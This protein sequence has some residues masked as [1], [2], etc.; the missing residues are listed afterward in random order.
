M[1]RPVPNALWGVWHPPPWL[2]IA[3]QECSGGV[4]MHSRHT[5]NTLF[6]GYTKK[7]Y[8]YISVNPQKG[9]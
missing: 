6:S 9:C 5:L 1:A 3:L 2:P 4:E 8:I 7:T